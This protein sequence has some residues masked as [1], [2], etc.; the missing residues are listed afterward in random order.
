MSAMGQAARHM[1]DPIE[2][3]RG[4]FGAIV[5]AAIGLAI[6]AAIVA[7]VV[8][9]GGMALAVVPVLM[10]AGTVATCGAF[11]RDIGRFIGGF[12][13]K[14]AG[15]IERGSPNVTVGSMML[16]AARVRDP[17]NC[18]PGKRI[19]SGCATITIND[20]PAARVEEKTECNGKIKEGCPSVIYGGPSVQVLEIK[21]PD[22]P[23]WFT[24]IS[25]TLDVVSLLG[26]AAGL[27]RGGLRLL[28]RNLLKPSFWRQ[29][30]N[31]LGSI[32]LYAFDKA[33]SGTS[34]ADNQYYQYGKLIFGGAAAVKTGRDFLRMRPQATPASTVRTPQ[35]PP[36]YM[37]NDAGLL[38]P[39]APA[40]TTQRASGLLVPNAPPGMRRTDGGLLLPAPP[41]RV[42]SPTGGQGT[43]L[44]PGQSPRI[45]PPRIIKP[46]DVDFSLPGVAPR[47]QGT[48][49]PGGI[50]LP[51]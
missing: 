39:T 16:Q 32:G 7:A 12:F 28:A 41:P 29:N 11:G 20:E 43:I 50:I 42:A 1:V 6:G 31:D 26:S 45:Q 44:L 9:S 21:S 2:H 5:G 33:V 10:A 40:G 25:N 51:N 38:V 24:W 35:P 34:L 22:D 18:H 30:W 8:F 17:V 3:D 15:D 27:A 49:T 4:L 48:R 47:V 19:A 46:G 13:N 37:R 36:G 14:N 23:W